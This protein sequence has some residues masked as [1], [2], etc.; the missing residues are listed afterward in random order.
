ML[1]LNET[2]ESIS[3]FP[4]LLKQLYVLSIFNTICGR[5]RIALCIGLWLPRSCINQREIAPIW[6]LISVFSN[7]STNR[8]AVW[9]TAVLLSVNGMLFVFPAAFPSCLVQMFLEW[10]RKAASFFFFFFEWFEFQDNCHAFWLP[11]VIP[12]RWA[13]QTMGCRRKCGAPV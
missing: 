2:G 12:V 9:A 8:I 11:E 1:T 6:F 4:Y 5:R 7:S 3:F 10:G 13:I